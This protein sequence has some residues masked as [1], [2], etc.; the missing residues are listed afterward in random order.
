[1]NHIAYSH[2]ASTRLGHGSALSI[3]R[4]AA[5]GRSPRTKPRSSTTTTAPTTFASTSATMGFRD[6]LIV[7]REE[8]K[9][10]AKAAPPPPKVVTGKARAPVG[11]LVA[12]F[13]E[14]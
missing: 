3:D 4:A 12:Y 10:C 5:G 2:D 7:R 11:K 8:S 13:D 9:A 6:P 14:S 1:M